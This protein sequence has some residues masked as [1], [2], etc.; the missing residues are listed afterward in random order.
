M[1]SLAYSASAREGDTSAREESVTKSLSRLERADIELDA[2]TTARV[3]E[4]LVIRG[5][6]SALSP[7]ERSRYYVQMCD[8]LGLNPASNP[9]AILR[10]NGKEILYPTRGATDQ[11]AAIH[12]LNRE[13]IDGPRV[14]DLAGTKMV[15]CVCRATHPNGRIETAI[16]QVPLTDPLNALMKCETKGKRRATLSI[17][18]LGML[19]ESELDTIPSHLKSPGT[20]IHVP[21]E[22]TAEST[23]AGG[24]S[25]VEAEGTIE[26]APPATEVAPAMASF[27]LGVEQFELPGEA[28]ALWIKHRSELA[29][30]TPADGEAAWKALCARTE[31]VG[32]MKNAKVWLKRAIAEEDARRGAPENGQFSSADPGA[33]TAPVASASESVAVDP[34]AGVAPEHAALAELRDRLT[35]DGVVPSFDALVQAFD[36]TVGEHG[37]A[38]A[39]VAGLRACYAHLEETLGIA[40][41]RVKFKGA[42]D[43][44]MRERAAA[45]RVAHEQAAAPAAAPEHPAVTELRARIAAAPSL[46]ALA[47]LGDELNAYSNPLRGLVVEAYCDRWCAVIAA[48]KADIQ[49]QMMAKAIADLPLPLAQEVRAGTEEAI[50]K[51]RA[52]IHTPPD[53]P[54]G[55]GEP[56]SPA[57]NTTAAAAAPRGPS[58]PTRATPTDVQRMRVAEEVLKDC[59]G[60]QHVAS[61]F[62]VHVGALPLTVRAAFRDFAVT[63]MAAKYRKT[64]RT[65]ETAAALLDAALAKIGAE[66]AA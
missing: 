11:L 44:R 36:E 42:V 47:A 19:D 53:G 57:A 40:K 43:A 59:N 9:F 46:L 27:L 32:R 51:R 20:P 34:L 55:G 37:D 15:F 62:A 21:V 56:P 1:R 31:H 54:Q 28:V 24:G 33:A 22:R 61:H 13:I 4:S 7:E 3:V 10:L 52:E 23:P 5:D 2:Q 30:L 25:G 16:A 63:F 14:I 66:V 60:P 17:L 6:I 12:K 29:T 49:V 38:D 64:V 65:H 35:Q 41:H 58:A 39:Q 48:A 45:K 50:A 8:S 26:D 18:G